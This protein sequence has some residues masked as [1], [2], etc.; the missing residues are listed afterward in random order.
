MNRQILVRLPKDFPWADRIF[1]YE[2][3]DSTNTRLKELA[4][5]GA[6][7]GTVVLARQQSGGRGRLGRSFS[8]A[9]GGVYL[10]VLLRPKAKPEELMHLT[11]AVGVAVC[12]AVSNSCGLEPGLKWINDLVIGSR[13]LGGILVELGFAPDGTVDYA[14]VGIGIN[15]CQ[16][17]E[18]FP[19]ELADIATSLALEGKP[20]STD[21]LA[22][23][24][25]K[26]MRQLEPML[27]SRRQ[28]LMN[29]YRSLCVTLGKPVQVL[30]GTEAQPAT[31]LDVLEDGALLVRY[32][33]GREE[34]VQ[35]G[36]VS[37]RGMYGYIS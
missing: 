3:L 15:C 24:L 16:Q 32:D 35:S 5:Q 1:L 18:D 12:M 2:E 26:A 6:S 28:E 37:V 7:A 9:K 21:L 10:S 19:P 31:A 13:K 29:R 11:C 25:I 8:S 23:N 30:R 14:V 4:R 20:C 34:A 27:L 33:D 22:A 36:E 17:Q